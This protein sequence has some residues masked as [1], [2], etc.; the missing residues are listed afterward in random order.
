[1]KNTPIQLVG[2][3]KIIETIQDIP[4]CLLLRG[5]E[6]NSDKEVLIK[7]YLPQLRWSD[8]LLNEFFDR[9]GYLKFIE[10][11]NLLAV[12]DFGKY[13]N[14]PYVVYPYHPFIFDPHNHQFIE[15]DQA[16]FLDQFCGIAEA[17]DY[18]HRQ[19]VVHGL[20]SPDVVLIDKTGSPKIFDHGLSEI[21]KKVLFEN[22]NDSFTFLSLSNVSFTAPELLSGGMPT[23][24]S[25]IYSYG[26]LFYLGIFGELPFKGRTTL[27][28]AILHL[29]N[30]LT[31][32]KKNSRSLSKKPVT[33]ISKSL[34]SKPDARFGS[35][36]EIIGIVGQIRHSTHKNRF[37][38]SE[39]QVVRPINKFPVAYD[40]RD[41][42][43]DSMPEGDVDQ[44]FDNI[45]SIQKPE[46]SIHNQQLAAQMHQPPVRKKSLPNWIYAGFLIFI[47]ASIAVIYYLPV[48]LISKP[49]DQTTLLLPQS[50]TAQASEAV[51]L[52]I[53]ETPIIQ[54]TGTTE[55]QATSTLSLSLP[56]EAS[57]QS[58]LIFKPALE[59]ERSK[60]PSDLIVSGNLLALREFSRLGY[61]KPEDTDISS[62]SKHFVVGTSAGVFIYENNNFHKLIDPGGWTT[63][64]QFSPDGSSL[65]IGL[66]TGEIQIWDW[67]TEKIIAR[68]TKDGHSLKITRILFSKSGRHLFSAS[69]D[70][71]VI[72]WDIAKQDQIRKI[73]AHAVPVEDIAV[74]DD[75]RTLI[76]GAGD[77]YV[78][79][80]DLSKSVIKP[81]WE[82]PFPG[83][84]LAVAITS[85][86]EYIAAGGDSG[87]ILQWSLVSRQKR[88]DV[89]P[90]KQRI[91][92]IEYIENNQT[93]F[94]SMDNG[95]V[96]NYSAT[97]DKYSGTSLNF[98]IPPVDVAL[99]KSLGSDFRG[100][101][102]AVTNGNS[103]DN[104]SILWNGRVR[105]RGKDLTQPYF[106]NLFRLVFSQD[107]NIISAQGKRG[108]TSVWNVETNRVL[109]KDFA[110]LPPGQPISSDNSTIALILPKT[111]H[112]SATGNETV[113]VNI[114][115]WIKLN[116]SGKKMDLSEVIKDGVVSY[117]QDGNIFIAGTTG[118]SKVW[119]YESGFETFY[120]SNANTGCQIT[121]SSNDETIFQIYSAAGT[122]FEFNE[123]TANICKNS[124]RFKQ[125][126]M[127]L[128][129]D[130]SL[131]AYTK[132]NGWL[133]AYDPILDK[134]LWTNNDYKNITAL[135]TSPDGS[136]IAVGSL[137]GTLIF[138]DG[139]TGEKLYETVGNYGSIQAIA[140]ANNGR[141]VA[142]AGS[143][144][145]V[146][147]FGTFNE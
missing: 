76:T 137:Q 79:I 78:R 92:G 93:L 36:Q 107:G 55:I 7:I 145:T 31:W 125:Y 105:S 84:V 147:L 87:R 24:Q 18:L 146:R 83:K 1:M 27:E 43:I 94:V 106:D 117:S 81:V 90:V 124:I 136:I 70:Q 62:D 2:S 61:G 64:V 77:Q 59:G 52:N 58:L 48:L 66:V 104:V 9:I 128:A 119:D 6:Q 53:S 38:K 11:E 129:N 69:N 89:I 35:F 67:K 34:E 23:R 8:Q 32:L 100:E 44:T 42:T 16:K 86:G 110:E 20:L 138:V 5:V 143:D 37:F 51:A 47:L 85:D 130:L 96:R 123:Q 95:E 133:E 102:Y 127:A 131:L 26:L 103:I 141:F 54:A 28:T 63:S 115:S 40:A 97:Q 134:V 109:Y 12:E 4:E 139:N 30:D 71:M 121:R 113:K 112:T 75:E 82:I 17:I 39:H 135:A 25:D 14:T 91:W 22:A 80:W 15:F 56:V 74:S 41:L 13:Q 68:L 101:S 72:M 122:F 114:Y 88:N 45:E 33:L 3:Y 46:P 65:A 111:I 49:E 126:Q 57:S 29:K 99:I 120:V 21:L 142:T 108:I 10:H 132:A 60:L 140:F 116:N 19:E 144:G 73:A 118:K 98:Q 50:I